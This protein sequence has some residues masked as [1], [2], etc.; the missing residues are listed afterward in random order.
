MTQDITVRIY[1]QFYDLDLAVNADEYEVVLSFF[2][3]YCSTL[4]TAESFTQ[5]LFRIANELQENVLDLLN[6]FEGSDSLKVSLTMAYYLNNNSNKTVMFGVNSV[7][8]PVNS[9]QRNVVE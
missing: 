1:D 6:T 8:R 4:K 5:T 2:K 3:Q 7:L 9:V